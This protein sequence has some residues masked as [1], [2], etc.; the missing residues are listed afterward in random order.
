MSAAP[1]NGG[2]TARDTA[3][4]GY[5]GSGERDEAPASSRVMV[6][7]RIRPHNMADGDVRDQAVRR[8]EEHTSSVTAQGRYGKQ[9]FAFDHVFDPDSHQNEVFEKIGT[10]FVSDAFNGYNCCIFAYGQTGSGKT[11]SMFG[12][13]DLF[14]REHAQERVHEEL[15]LLPRLVHEVIEE[16][17]RRQRGNPALTCSVQVS[18]LEIYNEVVH[19]LLD[20]PKGATAAAV[21]SGQVKLPALEL[22]GGSRGRWVAKELKH[23]NVMSVAAVMQLINKGNAYR[24]RDATAMSNVSSRSHSVFT[25]TL[26]QNFEPPQ[27]GTRDKEC[28]LTVVDLAGSERL[29]KTHIQDAKQVDTAEHI[30]KSLLAL[31]KCLTACSS[32]KREHVPVRE[33]K[34]TRLLSDVFGG[35]AKSLMFATV[36]PSSVNAPESISTLDYAAKAKK[37]KHNAKANVMAA[38]LEVGQLKEEV[39]MLRQTLLRQAAKAKEQR[40]GDQ[41]HIDRLERETQMLRGRVEDARAGFGKAQDRLRELGGVPEDSMMSSLRSPLGAPPSTARLPEGPTRAPPAKVVKKQSSGS[42]PGQA[43]ITKEEGGMIGDDYSTDSDEE[44]VR[45]VRRKEDIARVRAEFK[46]HPGFAEQPASSRNVAM[47][48]SRPFGTARRSETSLPPPSSAAERSFKGHGGAVYSCCLSR[49]GA[50]IV[51]SSRDKTLK[52]WNVESGTELRTFQ[53]HHGF[54]LGCDISS[55]GDL[56]ASAGDDKHVRVWDAVTGEQ[57]RVLREHTDKVYSVHFAPSGREVASASNDRT[58]RVWD[59]KTGTQLAVLTGHTSAVF[60][61]HFAPDGDRVASASDDRTLRV[62]RWR[63][64]TEEA[65]FTGHGDTVWSCRWHP[66]GKQL[67]SASVDGSARLWAL[68]GGETQIFKGHTRPVHHAEFARDA[69]AVVTASFDNTLRVWDVASGRCIRSLTDHA[70]RVYCCSVHEDLIVSCSGDEEIKL[71]LLPRE[72][73][74]SRPRE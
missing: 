6:A 38:K 5:S 11:Y 17:Q 61:A 36:S 33:S 73:P 42:L 31:G 19:D 66:D 1:Q 58:L 7:V 55:A 20:P 64:K 21:Q 43:G 53:G 14:A 27:P 56:I 30:N 50:R 41:K 74:K 44:R 3:R 28:R 71:W 32:S 15:G 65:V 69:S 23:V 2:D 24:Q 59:A 34:L 68:G 62:W 26:K 18:F 52:M 72:K 49:D 10:P 63:Q 22:V 60:C 8:S 37:I 39:E 40:E 25:L 70:G 12:D 48:S 54:V 16:C 51:S 46:R 35:N 13:A 57:T 9:Q 45:E 29:N 4:G 67:L 47:D